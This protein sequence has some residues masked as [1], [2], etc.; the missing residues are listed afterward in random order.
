MRSRR[1]HSRRAG[2]GGSGGFHAGY[3]PRSGPRPPRP[4]GGAPLSFS[5]SRSSASALRASSPRTIGEMRKAGV[6][7]GC[8]PPRVRWPL[9]AE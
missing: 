3:L 5:I 6:E 9:H 2:D 1:L 8:K 7:T 4:D